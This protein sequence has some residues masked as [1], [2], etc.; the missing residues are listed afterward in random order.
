MIDLLNTRLFASLSSLSQ[1]T[2][3]EEMRSAYETFIV[4]VATISQSANN[5]SEIFR[6]LNNTRIELVFI[7]SLYQYEQEKKCA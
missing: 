6:V 2:T 5:Y 4:Q 1:E 3:D 7:E